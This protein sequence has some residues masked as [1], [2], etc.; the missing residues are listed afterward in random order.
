VRDVSGLRGEKFSLI[1][2]LLLNIRREELSNFSL[3]KRIAPE[4]IDKRI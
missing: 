2:G 3:K 4:N 1:E